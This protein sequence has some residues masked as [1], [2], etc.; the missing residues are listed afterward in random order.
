MA[1][2]RMQFDRISPVALITG[3]ASGLGA[4][5][6]R[7]VARRA[8]GGLILADL[9]GAGLDATADGLD[10]PPERV[11]TLAFDVADPDR[12]TQASGFI[13]AQYGRLDWAVLTAGGHAD[14]ES[15]LVQWGPPDDL[16]SVAL[17]L[18]SVTPLMRYNAQGGA[19]VVIAPATIRLPQL[20]GAAA[21]EGG[22]DSIRVNAITPGAADAPAWRTAPLFQ[23]LAREH[24]GEHGALDALARL[25]APVVRY[26]GA[27]DIGRLVLM[28]LS[29]ATPITG[30]TLVVD[31]A[32][33][34]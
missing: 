27:C 31:G 32:Y 22:R 33:T 19:V 34:I 6:A 15:D 16:E 29:D 11:S 20:I 7:D 4:A 14:A 3:A 8:E 26:A 21:Q 25:P 1:Y 5:C 10:R 12:W 28:L 24:G 30:A 13:R 2:G 23:D 17:S 18:R 9:D